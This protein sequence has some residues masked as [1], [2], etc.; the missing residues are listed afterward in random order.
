MDTIQSFISSNII[1]VKTGRKCVDGRYKKNT[2]DSGRIAR[3]GGD[4][5]YVMALL[6]LQ[7]TIGS[8]YLT[9]EEC[10]KRVYSALHTLGE[11]F[12]MHTDHHADLKNPDLSPSIGCGHA[13]KS[14]DEELSK[15]YELNSEDMK[16]LVTYAKKQYVKNPD[17][18]KLV[19]LKGDH[20]EEAVIIVTGIKKTIN[21]QDLN[22]MGFIYDK[23]RDEK[24]IEKIFPLLSLNNQSVEDFKNKLNIQTN[25]TLKL[26]AKGLPMYEVNV[27]TLPFRLNSL[28]NVT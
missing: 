18:I 23:T 28:G 11:N 16:L 9:P 8:S 19:T 26:L 27:D 24:F 10:F 20:K 21:S 6:S 14:M 15:G 3:P 12:Y 17:N 2:D 4:L 5:G 1:T 7:K 22:H 25:A 13:A